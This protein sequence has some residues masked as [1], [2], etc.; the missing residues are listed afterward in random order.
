[1]SIA[2]IFLSI[3]DSNQS[4]SYGLYVF[5]EFSTMLSFTRVV[6]RKW[7]RIYGMFCLLYLVILLVKE[8]DRL[9]WHFCGLSLTYLCF[10]RF[11]VNHIM[12]SCWRHYIY[13]IVLIVCYMKILKTLKF[14]LEFCSISLQLK[15]LYIRHAIFIRFC[16]ALIAWKVIILTFPFK[17]ADFTILTNP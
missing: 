9:V 13:Y 12:L 15:H 8:G 14:F 2:L 17:A 11:C 3:F 10:I 16:N 7:T 5:R 6:S 1:M 4:L